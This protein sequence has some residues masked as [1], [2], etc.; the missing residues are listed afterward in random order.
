MIVCCEAGLLD[1]ARALYEKICQSDGLAR[2][3][4]RF[5]MVDALLAEGCHFFGDSERADTIYRRLARGAGANV[6]IPPGMALW[7]PITY[8]LGLLAETN[9]NLDL[10]IDH[11]EDALA[12]TQTEQSPPLAAYVECALGRVLLLRGRPEDRDR[13]RS[14][15]TSALATAER[16]GMPP[17]AERAR[18]LLG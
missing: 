13:A 1:E 17:L 8:Y 16:L 5:L 15:F 14:L 11:F 18:E 10:A 2:E 4:G 9:G 7:W 3:F 6:A 12:M